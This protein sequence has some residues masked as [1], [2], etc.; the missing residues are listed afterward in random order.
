MTPAER[1]LAAYDH[2]D[3][4]NNREPDADTAGAEWLTWYDFEYLPAS[5][6][7]RTA[8]RHFQGPDLSSHPY[9]VLPLA[10]A[11]VAK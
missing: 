6:A 1:V 2:L 7:W 9:N 5:A 4:V 3:A 10:H 11:A 8:V